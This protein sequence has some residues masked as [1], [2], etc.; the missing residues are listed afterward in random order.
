MQGFKNGLTAPFF[1][2]PVF[3][4]PLVAEYS[5]RKEQE[6]DKDMGKGHNLFDLNHDGKVDIRDHMLYDIYF[7]DD[8]EKETPHREVHWTSKDTETLGGIIGGI[9]G[10]ILGCWFMVTIL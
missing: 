8:D 5:H 7:G 2:C 10:I 4:T 3:G 6:E 1:C 9:I